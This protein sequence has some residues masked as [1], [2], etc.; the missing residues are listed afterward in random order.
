MKARKLREGI[1]WVG[2]IDWNLR[3]FH[4]YMTQRGSTYNAYLIIDEKITLIDNVKY[5][6]YDE[7][8][9]RI[10][11][12]I[13]PSKIDIL[14]QNH[15]EMDHSGGMPRLMEL[16][17]NATIYTNANGIKG[18]KAHYKKDWKFQ[19]V[20]TGD[21]ISLGKRSLHFVT[22]PMVHWPDNMVSYC[23]EEK[24]LFSNDA[25]GQ[26]I[27][28]SERLDTEYPLTIIM[29]EAKKYYANIVLP[30]SKQVQKVLDQAS[31]LDIEM[32][33]PSHGIIWTEHIPQIVQAYKDWAYSISKMDNALVI[34]DSM[35]KSTEQM[36]M[37]ILEAFENLGIK[38]KLY[39]LQLT[40][41]S[42]IMTDVI[43]AHWICVGSPTLNSSILP[44]VAAFMYYLKGLS[45]K[46]R[47]GLAF[48]SYGWGGQ[49]IP[50][51]HQLLGDPKECGFDML[52]PIKQQYIPG[53]E[54][55]Q[56]MRIKLEQNIKDKME[57]TK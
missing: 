37:T 1:Y 33:C 3:N 55:L 31:G 54:D 27:S 50:I 29:E 57:E 26:H 46:E 41:I 18:L 15:V 20:K 7:M 14:V 43:D 56:Q 11:E 48:G 49:S 5:Y 12:I 9:S 36:A 42:D 45:P 17:P 53:K 30:Y 35:W 21:S 32:I 25:F 38:T 52:E 4:G 44:T 28:S 6:L 19:E 16:L 40:H 39:N 47:V 23:P 8:I 10:S 51:L 34:Y 2:G 22:T 13:D 24:I